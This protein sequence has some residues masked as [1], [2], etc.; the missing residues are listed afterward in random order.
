MKLLKRFFLITILIYALGCSKDSSDDDSG[1]SNAIPTII[2]NLKTETTYQTIT[3]FGGAN[4][5]WGTKSLTPEEAVNEVVKI[6]NLQPSQA[7]EVIQTQQDVPVEQ[8]VVVRNNPTIPKVGSG[9][10][11]PVKKVP[12]SIDDLRAL[13][14][15]FDY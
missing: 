11:S 13:A 5:M 7:P 3:G 14:D 4:R 8:K 1:D 9:S 6:Y 10:K 12:R 15:K 2:A